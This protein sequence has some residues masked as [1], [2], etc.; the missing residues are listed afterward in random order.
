MDISYTLSHDQGIVVRKN[1]STCHVRTDGRVLPCAV[2][3]QLRKQLYYSGDNPNLR[4]HSVRAVRELDH[5]DPLAVGDMVRFVDAGDGTG[6]IVEVL[7]RRNR[8]ARRDP[9][10]GT[11][12]FEQVIVA[13]VDIILPVFAAANPTPKWAMLDRYLAS[14]ESLDLSA[15]IVITKLDLVRGPEGRLDEELL[16]GVEEYRRIGY[17]VLLTSAFTGEGLDELRQALKGR[18]SAFVGKSG[19]GKTAL[20]NALEPGLGLRVGAVGKGQ[21]GKGRHT[22]TGAEMVPLSFGGDIVDTPGMREFGLHDM[23]DDDL[24]L[25]FPEMRPFVGRCR[26]GLDCR[27]DEEPGCAV[28]KAVMAGTISPHR[29]RSYLR[30]NEELYHGN[31]HF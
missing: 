26:F 30:M 16:E 6:M 14:I 4:H 2:S 28:R 29:Y 18:L 21:I 19:V 22:T 17:P 31:T 20:L 13:N 7:P 15:M 8:L 25:F 10:P 27:H 12:V 23:G 1:V 24:A 9:A 3:S 11:H 5:V